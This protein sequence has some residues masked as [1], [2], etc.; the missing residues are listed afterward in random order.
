MNKKNKS[1]QVFRNKVFG[2]AT[3]M[4]LSMVFPL[5]AQKVGA[6]PKEDIA[7]QLSNR[8]VLT[9]ELLWMDIKVWVQNEPSPSKVIYMELLDRE[10]VPVIQD[11]ANLN[12]GRS[13]AYLEIPPTINSDHYLLRVYTRI[14]PFTSGSKGVFQDIITIINPEKP[15]TISDKPRTVTNKELENPA[16]TGSIENSSSDQIKLTLPTASWLS[17]VIRK[18]NPTLQPEIALD[19]DKMYRRINSNSPLIPEL[20][21]HIIKGRVLDNTVDP[22]GFY[23][24][25]AHGKQFHFFISRPDSTGTCYFETGNFKHYEYVVVQASTAEREVNF[26]LDSP[27]WEARPD[28]SFDLPELI[29]SPKD[30]EF[31]EERL[32]ARASHQYYL[33][34]EK[35]ARDSIPFQFVTD[36]SYLL[37]DYNRFEDM[38]TVIREYVPTVLVRSQ[39]RTTIFKNFNL[40]FDEVFQE[41]PLLLIDGMPVFESDDF[42]KFNP[43]NIRKMDIINRNFYIKDHSFNGLVSLSSYENDFGRFDLP[44]KAL[45]IE[46]SGVQQNKKFRTE[47]GQEEKELHLPDFRNIL[48]WSNGNEAGPELYFTPSSLKGP[49]IM[50]LQYRDSL[51]NSWEKENYLIDL[52]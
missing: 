5:L 3:G 47:I 36:F 23:Y 29:M 19:F 14:S 21:G 10:G 27:F 33:A 35:V 31:L 32:L 30:R 4:V 46:Y 37:D 1:I 28:E 13:Q 17:V 25:T 18:A 22:E 12:K 45:F 43:K 38:A 51:E 15:P 48:Y 6:I 41:N 16:F 34:P 8:V 2:M 7:V 11:M 39:N 50:N 9:E 52:E 49:F 20:Y 42:A 24:L 40:P 44:A 26:I